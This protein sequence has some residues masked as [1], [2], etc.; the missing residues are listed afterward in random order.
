MSD[1]KPFTVDEALEMAMLAEG[2]ASALVPQVTIGRILDFLPSSQRPVWLHDRLA[3]SIQARTQVMLAR[4][5]IAA[6]M[7]PMPSTAA[8]ADE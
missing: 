8:A 1:G 2:A 7:R 6:P 5:L 4:G 3:G